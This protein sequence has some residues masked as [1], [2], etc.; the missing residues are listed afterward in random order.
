M[1]QESQRNLGS[2]SAICGSIPRDGQLIAAS[3]LT[4]DEA[5]MH[6]RRA[7]APPDGV[8]MGT[9]ARAASQSA[10][11]ATGGRRFR[12]SQ[13]RRGQQKSP[14]AGTDRGEERINNGFYQLLKQRQT[15]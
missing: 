14:A 12:A 8:P 4:R 13:F 15:A 6:C 3:S 7:C 5:E 9:T 10:W 1:L 2:S 11:Q